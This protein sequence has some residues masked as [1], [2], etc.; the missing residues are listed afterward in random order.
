MFVRRRWLV[1]LSVLAAVLVL[2]AGLVLWRAVELTSLASVSEEIARLKPLTAALRLGLIG[3]VAL[4]W[5]KVVDVVGCM[6]GADERTQALWQRLRWRMVGWLLVI[7]LLLGHNLLGTLGT[8]LA[9]VEG[10]SR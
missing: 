10:V 9:G 2:G 8:A 7:E 4:L 6:R 5:P 1:G 3:L